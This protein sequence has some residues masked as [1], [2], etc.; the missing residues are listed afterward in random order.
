MEYMYNEK[1]QCREK[2]R[3]LYERYSSDPN[4]QNK[5]NHILLAHKNSSFCDRKSDKP[6]H[7]VDRFGYNSCLCNF[8]HSLIHYFLIVEENFNRGVMPHSGPLSDQSAYIIDAIYLIQ[9]LKNQHIEEM[10]KESSKKG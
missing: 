8:S 1:F 2:E 10:K 4:A 3:K 9:S 7:Y 6:V 5:V